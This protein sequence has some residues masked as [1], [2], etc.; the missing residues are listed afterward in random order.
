[1]SRSTKAP[2]QYLLGHYINR[3]AE[4]ISSYRLHVRSCSKM[5]MSGRF[6]MDATKCAAGNKDNISGVA[7]WEHGPEGVVAWQ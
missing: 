5:G 7:W 2:Y 3:N 1:M 4:S 6:E